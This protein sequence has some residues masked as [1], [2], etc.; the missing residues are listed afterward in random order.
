MNRYPLTPLANKQMHVAL[1]VTEPIPA[2]TVR[3]ISEI[4]GASVYVVDQCTCS[5]GPDAVFPDL[6]DLSASVHGFYTRLAN[7]VRLCHSITFYDNVIFDSV[8]F[9]NRDITDFVELLNSNKMSINTDDFSVII[10][11]SEEQFY[12]ENCST[13]VANWFSFSIMADAP[14]AFSKMTDNQPFINRFRNIPNLLCYAILKA[15]NVDVK[16][17]K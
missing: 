2:D 11:T 15:T 8:I 14:R 7:S 16:Y 5:V 12:L 6:Y 9:V 17:F 3:F 4:M 13:I 10:K 1:C